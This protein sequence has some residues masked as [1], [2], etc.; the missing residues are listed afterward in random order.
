MIDSIAGFHDAGI[1]FA[2]SEQF[3]NRGEA[4]TNAVGDLIRALNAG[5]PGDIARVAFILYGLGFTDGASWQRQQVRD[6][7]TTPELPS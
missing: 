7:I 2:R 6:A 1:S 4:I 3:L 5:K